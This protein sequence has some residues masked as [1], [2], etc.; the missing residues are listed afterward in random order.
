MYI[1]YESKTIIVV[2][3]VINYI[4]EVSITQNST[5]T[6]LLITVATLTRVAPIL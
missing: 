1:E 4:N 6:T 2:V 3:V 5:Y